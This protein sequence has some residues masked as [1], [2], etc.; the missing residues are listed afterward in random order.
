[1]R[2]KRIG[3]VV[4]VAMMMSV[5][6]ANASGGVAFIATDAVSIA[7]P[8][9]GRVRIVEIL[10][11]G[12]APERLSLRVLGGAY[13]HVDVAHNGDTTEA[14]A[15]KVFRVTVRSSPKPNTKDGILL[16]TSTDGTSARLPL[17]LGPA[18]VL[19]ALAIPKTLDVGVKQTG[20]AASVTVPGLSGAA[21]AASVGDLYRAGG[22]H[23]EVSVK[24]E[25][26][27][28]GGATEP[29]EYSGDIDVNGSA[30]GGESTVTMRVR[31]D[32]WWAFFPLVIGIGIGFAIEWWLTRW[33]PRG[34]LDRRLGRLIQRVEARRWRVDQTLKDHFGRAHGRT[35]GATT[36][37]LPQAA[38]A[39]TEGDGTD[40]ENKV[41]TYYFTRAGRALSQGLLGA[42]TDPERELFGPDGDKFK[43]LL[44]NETTY[45]ELVGELRE[46]VYVADGVFAGLQDTNGVPIRD[47]FDYEVAQW[48]V[49]DELQLAARRDAAKALRVAAEHF[50][51]FHRRIDRAIR[52]N[53]ARRPRDPALET[54]LV[55]RRDE[56]VHTF[57]GDD[58]QVA[59]W[60][61]E[62]PDLEDEVYVPSAPTPGSLAAPPDPAQEAP[63]PGPVPAP[64][65]R[66]PSRVSNH[67]GG[68]AAV[69]DPGRTPLWEAKA[70]SLRGERFTAA[71]KSVGAVSLA[72][73]L[74][75]GM[76]TIYLANDT[77]GSTADLVA[78]L[79]W[80]STATTAIALVRRLLPGGLKTLN[81]A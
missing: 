21:K 41:D 57:H 69:D 52:L 40:G 44:T 74:A 80:G 10:N 68:T 76:A 11:G 38:I 51:E 39:R 81:D 72:T 58:D 56:L 15:T 77:F 7:K 32:A 3:F 5:A 35:T 18:A 17:R 60:G 79:L 34:L 73:V 23:V 1:M 75:S 53:E 59:W 4:S 22:Q 29:G 37:R 50:A 71:E 24:G 19:T 54:K 65:Q 6:P 28:V 67:P 43:A 25:K 49:G 8:T 47:R 14:G 48:I 64:P 42:R 70:G 36:W 12:R 45:A 66:S 78:A 55:R 2:G 16:A 9:V 46:A 33:R 31:R 27:T 30:A 62:M 13:R 26:V 61:N 20:T 63:A